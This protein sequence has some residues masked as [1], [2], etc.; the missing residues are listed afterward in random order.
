M[1]KNDRNNWKKEETFN[2]KKE[3][4]METM[5]KIVPTLSRGEENGTDY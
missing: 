1:I 2:L 3:K 4:K 5:E